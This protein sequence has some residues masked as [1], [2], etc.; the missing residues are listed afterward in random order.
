MVTS[1]KNAAFKLLPEHAV[2]Y[3]DNPL[4][5]KHGPRYFMLN[6]P[7]GYVCSTSDTNH[8]TI[9]YFIS[10][11]SRWRNKLYAAGCLDIDTTC[12]VLMID[13]DQWSHRITSPRH[14]CEKPIW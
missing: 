3:D 2:A 6:K 9:L 14:H 10:W 1:L 8:P 12:L 4:V 7:Q 13:D 11:M 5:Q